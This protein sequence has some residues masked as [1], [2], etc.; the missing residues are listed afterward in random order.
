[1]S[2]L[3]I[4]VGSRL[5][6][7]YHNKEE[8]TQDQWFLDTIRW[9]YKLEFTTKPQFNGVKVTK[10]KLSFIQQEVKELLEKQVIQIVQ[11]NHTKSGFDSILFP[12]SQENGRS[13]TSHK[14]QIS[15]QVHVSQT[16]TLQN[17]FHE[18]CTKPCSVRRLCSV[19]NLKD[20]YLHIP[21]FQSHKK[22]LRFCVDGIKCF[23]VGLTSIWQHVRTTGL[24]VRASIPNI[25]K[26][27]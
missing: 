4:A 16:S 11:P 21:I 12:S 22:F 10:G 5:K 26:M 2:R 27:T 6:S 18:I 24:P 19:Y 17:G 20:A 15:K 14:S 13:K 3:E 7:F 1:M 9:G 25:R 23:S 8:I